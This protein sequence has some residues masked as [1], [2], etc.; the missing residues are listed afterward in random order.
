MRQSKS[1]TL[2]S[3]THRHSSEQSLKRRFPR[4]TMFRA[5][6]MFGLVA[7]M[8]LTF[9]VRPWSRS[10]AQ[11][12]KIPLTEASSLPDAQ[13][14]GMVEPLVPVSQID[15]PSELVPEGG[16]CTWTPGTVVPITILDQATA[17]VGG[18][19]YTF[20]GVSTAI[21]ANAYK[22][23]GTTWTPITNLPQALEFPTAVSDGTNIYIAGGALVGTGTPQT[24]LYRYN[25]ATNDY[26]TLAPFTTPTWNQALALLN[27]KIYKFAGTSTAA[28]TNVLEIYDIAGNSW[29][30][31]AVYP[32]SIS[33]VSAFVRNGFVYGAGGIQ[34]VGSVASLKTYRYDPVG[35]TWDD[36]AIADM[37]QTRWGSAS[38]GVGYGSNGG[39]LLAAGYVNGTATA[40]ISTSVIRWDPVGN[41]WIDLPSLP[42]GGDRSRMTGAILN[43]SFY[44]VG[45]RSQASSGFVGTNSNQ[46][47]TCVSNVAVIN[48]GSTSIVSESCPPPNGAPDP[49]ET[50]TVSLPV[51]NTGDT[52]TTNLMVTLQATGGVT[53]PSGPVN[54]GAVAA[55]GMPVTNNF[56]FT[57][58]PNAACG[59]TVTLTFTFADGATTYPNVV[60]NYTTGTLAVVLAQNFD[61]VTAPALP[62][63]W[64]NVQT[65]G[66]LINWA[67]SATT[68]SSAPN[69]AFAN[70]PV[71]VN[72]AA[73]VSP[74]VVINSANAQ[75][76]FKN[77]F[78]TEDTFD[79]M[80]LEF[81]T[82]GGSTWTDVITGG[83]S[84][85]SGGYTDTISANFMSPISGRMA[86]SGNSGGYIDTVVN[87]P[88]SLNGQTVQFR[89]VM[90][91]DTTVSATGVSVDNIQIFGSRVCSSCGPVCLIQRRNDFNGDGKTDYSV[92]RPSNGAWYILPNGGGSAT[93]TTFGAAGD[94][95][96]PVD[97][98]GDG[99]TDL[100]LYR[101]GIWYWL[102][103]S[104][105][106]VA[107]A[108]FGAASDIPVA[109]D[110][111]GD[112][113]ADVA[114][115]R[116]STGVWYIQNS[117]TSAITATVWGGNATDVPAVGDF[118][119]DCRMDL[120]VRRT[121]N[122]PNSGDTQFI[123]LQSTAGAGS[124]RWGK[125]TYAMAIGDYSGDGKSEAG[126]VQDDAGN[127]RWF[128]IGMD[129]IQ[130][131]F[132]QVPFGV[133]G[134]IVT[135]GDYDGDLKTDRAVWRSSNQ[136]FYY[137]PAGPTT[138]I[139]VGP[140][141]AA[142]DIPTARA[143]QY[144]L[145]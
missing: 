90:A 73:L 34:S 72:A 87:L 30:Q 26:T 98:D 40:N 142:G 6:L 124:V 145:P 76:S 62:A 18:N 85:A 55:N 59:S 53:N 65:S 43:S 7:G 111:T 58:N 67:T 48:G 120:A 137:T 110:Y 125:D 108:T 88:A 138:P 50:L 78:I 42:V 107:S 80:V 22:F 141:G 57:V 99:K 31:G 69:T 23:D 136:F 68:P 144:P 70:D 54:Y 12:Q 135:A 13:R 112:G 129:N 140:F 103:S 106:T 81:T 75:V 117:T 39:W 95:L 126:V 131:V 36:A 77:N 102:R 15:A 27:G 143:S 49:G 20:G 44:V 82:N 128:A 25:V 113:K 37:P 74:A 119:G 32:L 84:F 100:G 83:G 2:T 86:W 63:G 5:L 33:F 139:Y 66:T 47:L 109:G 79:G 52:P 133:T 116:P 51:T 115:Y 134:D 21:I 61:G 24:T 93:G 92:F 118:D 8:A 123:V 45:G 38:S 17:S 101:S 114:V 14:A 121:V 1:P 97:Y 9:A 71:G 29:T 41:T 105:S 127:L 3:S 46:K 35:N 94:K 28:S 122:T 56:T 89:W 60:R 4:L 19:L 11:E 10:T 91:S 132:G 104:D 130:T 16:S 96:Q 64:T